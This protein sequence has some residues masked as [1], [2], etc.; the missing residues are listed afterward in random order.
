MQ[1]QLT[2]KWR[3][4]ESSYYDRFKSSQII[5]D[6]ERW[7]K[8]MLIDDIDDNYINNDE[9]FE[10]YFNQEYCN[11]CNVFMD[12]YTIKRNLIIRDVD[13][14]MSF[15]RN[16]LDDTI[17]DDT[18]YYMELKEDFE[19][20]FNIVIYT[21]ANEIFDTIKSEYIAYKKNYN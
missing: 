11:I 3:T 13:D 16:N 12:F 21:I 20:Q 10:E 17:Y 18:N 15:V 6:I 19:K 14:I 4:T 2:N 8:E 1:Q 5:V 9:D 7:I